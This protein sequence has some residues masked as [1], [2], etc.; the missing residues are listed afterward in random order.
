MLTMAARGKNFIRVRL[1]FDYPPPALPDCRM[2]W[3][4]VD[5]D[6]CRVVADLEGVVREQ[7]DFSRGSVLHLFIESCYLPHTESI[8]VVRDNDSVRVKVE[9]VNLL[10][11]D[12]INCGER[13]NKSPKKR[14][15]P[16]EETEVSVDL[17]KKRRD[18]EQEGKQT[19]TDEKE[20]K[21]QAKSKVKKKR[22]TKKQDKSAASTS[23]APVGVDQPA[24]VKKTPVAQRASSSD[25]SSSSSEEE[26]AP[27]KQAPN[28]PPSA[29]ASSRKHKKNKQRPPSSS[30]SEL[31]LDEAAGNNCPSQKQPPGQNDASASH[32]TPPA[33][34]P[35]SRAQKGA[36]STLEQPSKPCS[37]GSE[38]EIQFVI[39]KPVQPPGFGVGAPSSRRGLGSRGNNRRDGCARRG[40]GG[41][42]GGFPQ[43]NGTWDHHDNHAAV[44]P[45]YQTDSLT[46][47][48]VVLQ[49]EVE[50]TP[51]DYS[52]MPLLAAP[53]Q[54]G[55]KIA[56]KV[57]ELT[58]SYSP[59]ISDY[60]VGKMISFDHATQQIELELQAVSQAP[61]EPG[62]FDLVYQNPDGT[63]IVE[64]AVSRDARL[65]ERW[66]CLHEPRL[67][68]Q[69]GSV[70]ST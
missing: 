24:Q 6:T 27:K 48:S 59:E 15:R 56:F 21:L 20:K 5:L 62:K 3:L 40:R 57:L 55:Q 65:V 17:K 66:D 69:I 51:V 68:I 39:R 14:R 7:F 9:R 26:K 18:E 31:S 34:P 29:P 8:Y 33:E 63:E 45:S 32:P 52:S 30:S 28:T 13:K 37:S 42:R 50:S 46:N 10:N 41:N 47:A 35:S 25:P 4:L 43:Q 22:K 16:T 44:T 58:D 19:S 53:P 70:P 54:V 2:C 60:K 36:S 38:E 1:E 23:I 61:A 49:N 12:S 11:G 67:I 64:Y